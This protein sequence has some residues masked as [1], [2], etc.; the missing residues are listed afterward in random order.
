GRESQVN[1]TTLGALALHVAEAPAH[2]HGKFIDEGRI[3]RG[4]S[5]LPDSDQGSLDRLVRAAFRRQRDAGRR[6]RH[7]EA[8]ILIAGIV[9]RIEAAPEEG[10]V[11][12]AD[13][14]QPRTVDL[15]RQ[16]ERREHDEQ[17]HLGDTELEVLALRRI[18]PGVG[19]RDLLLPEQVVVLRLG[20]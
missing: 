19:R 14:Q 7:H 8:R 3:E 9:Q 10:I 13:R 15:V 20:E 12:R 5:V 4:E 6:R 16:A 18:L 1:R 2:D 11:Q 17:I